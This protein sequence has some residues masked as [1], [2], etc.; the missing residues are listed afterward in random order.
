MPAIDP[1][2]RVQGEHGLVDELM[3]M[4]R[5]PQAFA[6][7]PELRN[8]AFAHG[9]RLEVEHEKPFDIAAGI[10]AVAHEPIVAE[11]RIGGAAIR[12][13]DA[14]IGDAVAAEPRVLRLREG[15]Q[16]DVKAARHAGRAWDERFTWGG[17]EK[18][19]S[20]VF[21]GGSLFFHG[22]VGARGV[23]PTRPARWA[24][25]RWPTRVVRMLSW[26]VLGRRPV[27]P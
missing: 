16:H 10:P 22:L 23:W 25:R 8:A 20:V 17:V 1:G 11:E 24:S 7:L 18:L 13:H 19:S 2:E 15:V 21:G 27:T 6:R 26:V 4:L 3:R 12:A 5:V 9:E 14:G